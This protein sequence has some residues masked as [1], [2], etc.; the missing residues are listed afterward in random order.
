MLGAFSLMTALPYRNRTGKGQYIELALLDSF[1]WALDNLGER[2]T[3][4][5]EVLTRA[6]HV[7]CGGSTSGVYRTTDGHVAI[8]AGSRARVWRRFCL[9]IGRPALAQDPQDATTA[10]RRQ[11]RDEIAALIQS[12]TSTQTKADVVCALTTAGVPAAS[13][14]NVAERV[15]APPVRAREMF[16]ALPHPTYDPVTITETP[17]KLSATPGRVERLAPLPG[18]PHEAICVGLLGGHA[19]DERGRWPEAGVVEGDN[20]WGRRR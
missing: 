15:A 20:R 9:T 2:S 18:E 5:G 1:V 19:P 3:V 7:S 13:V 8:G 17:F 11:R 16:G 14:H 6:G 12:W 10:A 4:G